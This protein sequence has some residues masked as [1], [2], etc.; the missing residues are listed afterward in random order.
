MGVLEYHLHKLERDRVILSRRRGLY[1][2]YYHNL[3]FNETDQNVLDVLSQETERDILLY[4]I[5]NPG[6]RQADLAAYTRLT[7]STVVWHL[8]RLVAS[9]LVEARQVG[10]TVTY[11]TKVDGDLVMR[12]LN[13]YHPTLLERLSDRLAEVVVGEEG[14]EGS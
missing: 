7:T 8:K 6:T 3:I 5:L 12:L 11:A 13:D 14:G 9:G 2:R 10:S 4:T 1:R